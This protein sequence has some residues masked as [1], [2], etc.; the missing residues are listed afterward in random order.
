MYLNLKL[1]ILY[2]FLLLFPFFSDS[3]TWRLT[4]NSSISLTKITLQANPGDTILIHPGNYEVVNLE[5]TKPLHI[6]GIDFPIIDG[7]KKGAI[8]KFKTDSFTLKGVVIKNVGTSVI[9]DYAGI[10]VVKSN[11]FQID[12]VM[13]DSIFFGILCEKSKNGIISH[14]VIRG[15]AL[16]EVYSGNGIHL[17]KCDSMRIEYNEIF[18]TRDGIYFEFVEHSIIQ[19]NYSHDNYRYGLHFMF[20]N[21][22]SYQYNRFERCGAGVA[23]M[24]SRHITM[25]YNIFNSNWGHAAYG[26]LLKEIYDSQIENNLFLHNT[27]AIQIETCTRVSYHKNYFY[28]NGWALNMRGG[29][30]ENHFYQNSF[31]QN[32]FDV[33]YYGRL[34]QNR[35]QKNYWDKYV[36]YDLNRDHIGDIPHHPVELFSYIVNFIPESVVLLHSLLSELLNLLEK[37]VPVITPHEIQD[38]QPTLHP[39]KPPI[40]LN[41]APDVPHYQFT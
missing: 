30:Y 23:V 25:T 12:S 2:Y 31:L 20:S 7:K 19:H 22:D 32:T 26:L 11:H 13:M 5:I 14:C 37:V 29:T 16:D 17:W 33:A 10:L 38:N 4:P 9:E 18:R 28:G 40:P 8:F 34:N 3:K 6:I 21:Y 39:N 24:F 1:I 27:T 41:Y 15:H 35:F 36:G